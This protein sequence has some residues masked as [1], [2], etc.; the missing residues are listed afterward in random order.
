MNWLLPSISSIYNYMF[1]KSKNVVND[2]PKDIIQDISKDIIN[3]ISNNKVD[4]IPED[5][6]KDITI[7]VIRDITLDII[8]EKNII[9][10]ISNN[11]ITID[12]IRDTTLNTIEEKNKIKTPNFDNLSKYIIFWICIYLSDEDLKSLEQCNKKY[13]RIVSEE[14]P[15]WREKYTYILFDVTTE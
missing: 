4:N 3:D 12:V 13:K 11:K 8:E 10:D 15:L 2:I 6:I 5:I 9:N 14:F 1:S 7:D